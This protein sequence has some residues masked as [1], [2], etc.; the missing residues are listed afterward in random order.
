VWSLRG[1]EIA[2]KRQTTGCNSAGCHER[3]WLVRR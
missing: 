2:F 3:I 1:A